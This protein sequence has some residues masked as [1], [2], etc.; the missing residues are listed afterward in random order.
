MNDSPDSYDCSPELRRAG[1]M[2]DAKWINC[3]GVGGWGVMAVDVALV[4]VGGEWKVVVVV[5]L[6]VNGR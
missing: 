5:L 1:A 4:G 6:E 2:A 3:S